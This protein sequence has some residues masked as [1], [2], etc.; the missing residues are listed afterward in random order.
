MKRKILFL[1]VL[2]TIILKS[3]YIYCQEPSKAKTDTSTEKEV[4]TVVEEQPQFP[5]GENA[6]QLF[7]AQNIQYPEKAKANN[8]EGIVFATFIVE[9][10]GTISHVKILKGIGSG[11]DEE[12]IRVLK[13]MPAWKPGFQRGKNVR[14]KIN[15]PVKFMFEK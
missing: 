15:M 5:G 6:R 14:V 11:C 4:F 12:V 2:T 8:I 1:V 10:D 9:T 7:L 13:K 3:S